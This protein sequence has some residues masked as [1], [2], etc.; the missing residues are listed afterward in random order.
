MERQSLEA[1]LTGTVTSL[2]TITTYGIYYMDGTTGLL[3]KVNSQFEAMLGWDVESW[4]KFISAIPIEHRPRRMVETLFDVDSQ[5]RV[6]DNLLRRFEG[7]THEVEYHE[8][9]MLTKD[10]KGIDVTIHVRPVNENGRPLIQGFI[11][12]NTNYKDM[13]QTIRELNDVVNV[14]VT[15]F[16]RH[17][18]EVDSIN[19]LVELLTQIRTEIY[20]AAR[21]Q[22]ESQSEA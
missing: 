10:G 21:E 14:M 22:Q 12:D 6:I 13:L 2:E 11:A 20:N 19:E 5:E 16:S 3:K 1:K 7:S 17:H 9:G 15:D 18:N 4:N 8:I